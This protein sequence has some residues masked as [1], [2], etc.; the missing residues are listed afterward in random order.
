MATVSVIRKKTS[1]QDSVLDLLNKQM[2]KEAYSSSLYLSMSAW[3]YEQGLE[4]SGK[5]FKKQSAEEREHMMRIFDYITDM[6]ALAI[7]PEV[8][9]VESSFKNLRSV[10][11]LALESEISITESFNQMTE[12]CH[13]VRDFQTVKFFDWFLNEQMEEEQ[14][15]RRCIELFDIIGAENGGLYKIDKEVL[16]L[17]DGE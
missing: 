15:A 10:F 13:K 11:E 14:Q 17:K 2:V 3:C 16:K 4:N 1:L 5:F 8:P 7:S 12:H 9:K 6:G